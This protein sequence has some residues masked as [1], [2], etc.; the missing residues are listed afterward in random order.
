MDSLR[1]AN[2]RMHLDGKKHRSF[3]A[4]L[5]AAGELRR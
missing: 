3:V 5:F 1:I 4:M 2:I